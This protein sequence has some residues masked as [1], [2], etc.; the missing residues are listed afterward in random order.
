MN[1]KHIVT[2]LYEGHYEYGVGALVNS[3]VSADF[4]GLIC[5]AYKG[6]LP[7]WFPQLQSTKES[8]QLYKIGEKVWLRFDEINVDMHFGY[9]KPYYLKQM[10][11]TYPE[12]KGWFYFDPD[13]IVIGKWSFY[14]DWI[15]SGVAICQDSNY[16][17][18]YWNHP[19][20][21]IWRA[22]FKSSDRGVDKTLNYYINS[23]FIG[24]NEQHFE[25]INRWI[26]VNEVYKALGYPIHFFNQR[27]A[28]SAYKG[29][30][31]VL[32]AALT[33]SP[34][35]TYS[36]IGK[37]AMAFDFPFAI[38]AHAVDGKGIK[39]WKRN[40]LKHAL[41]GGKASVTDEVYLS[42]CEVP[43]RLYDSAELK[44]KR[45]LLKLSKVINRFWKK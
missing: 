10:T 25:I 34:D 43:V 44:K 39:P 23:G 2:T 8:E 45:F 17:I 3:L 33:L 20:R 28:L 29:D 27:A 13:I 1:Y 16:S 37:E 18:L 24:V 32:N 22:D 5:V 36:I 14:E 41:K 30:Q 7:F 42:H 19:W 11:E 6:N 15:K 12:S 38:M 21:N 40:Y 35:L 26:E 31:D 9:F 4:E